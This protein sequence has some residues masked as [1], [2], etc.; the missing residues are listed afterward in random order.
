MKI[1]GG[2]SSQAL[3]CRVAAGLGIAP[4]I[5]DYIRFPDNEQYLQIKEDISG[6]DIVLIQST[7]TDSDLVA[8]LQLLDACESAAAITV[9]IPYMGYAR[10]DKK[11]KEGE[12]ISA[13]AMARAVS[14]KNLKQI[15]T[16]NLHEKSILNYF[17]CPAKD[18]DASK[19]IAEYVSSLGLERPLLIAPDKGVRD[20]VQ[21]M[22]A[23]LNLDWDV[24]DKT[25]LAG[26]T[27][28]IAD[29]PMD[30]K[31]RD[32]IIVD[33]MIATGGT[34]AEA[35]NILDKNGAKDVYVACIHP[36]LTR[37]AVLR[38]SNAGVKDIMA[39]D[40]IEKVQSRIS[41][42]PIIIHALK[43]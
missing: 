2:P 5:T 18:L 36:V 16:I 29:K 4:T 26:D 39:T 11:F 35:V 27:V 9:V 12:A 23:G 32:I 15:Y 33:D 34:M 40:T 19:L 20:M 21:N 25:R 22:A 42:A 31:G 30:I 37:N 24:F 1:I 41:T 6:E 38:L 14:A 7:T 13:R 43:K 17:S 8:L 28:V 10:Q 3:A